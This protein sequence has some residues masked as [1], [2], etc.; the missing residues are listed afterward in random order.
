MPGLL[1]GGHV[2]I[3]DVPGLG[4]DGD[5]A[6]P[7]QA[8]CCVRAHPVHAR[9][10]AR[11]RHRLVDLR[12][13][14]E[15][16][17]VPAGTDLHGPPARRR[18]QPRAAKTQSAL[19]EAMQER[20]V[21]SRARRTASALPSSSSRRRTRSSTKARIRCPRRSSTVSS[22]Q[23]RRLP[24]A[25][26]GWKILER[27]IERGVVEIGLRTPLIDRLT[28][29][30][31]DAGLE[32][33]RVDRHWPVHRRSRRCHPPEDQRPISSGPRGSLRCSSS[34]MEEPRAQDGTTLVP[35]GM[36]AVADEPRWR[37]A[38]HSAPGSGS[39]TC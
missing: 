24:I 35:E 17:R 1:A 34:H 14:H 33:V 30:R 39:R 22:P 27:R 6:R 13:A 20:Q 12:P 28:C 7:R 2:L 38:S 31:C 18:D 26:D 25:R 21:P 10:D 32:Q 15:R 37:T 23:P 9:P 36:K 5:G 4:E 8:L 3:E 19:L 16:L 29:W 11:R